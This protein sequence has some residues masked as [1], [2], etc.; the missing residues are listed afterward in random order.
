MLGSMAFVSYRKQI[1][2]SI[3]ANINIDMIGRVDSLHT[4][5]N[6][7]LYL[8]GAGKYSVLGDAFSLADSLTTDIAIDYS[9]DNPNDIFGMFNLSDQRSFTAKSIPAVMVTSGL[10]NDYHTPRD[11]PNRLDYSQIRQRV[12]LLL[13]AIVIADKE[14]L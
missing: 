8:L 10:H 9:L 3:V 14:Y 6:G 4:K 13:N 2:D 12:I 5:R 7:Y 11:T 1:S